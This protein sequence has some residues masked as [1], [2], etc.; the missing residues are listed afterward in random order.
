MKSTDK[1]HVKHIKRVMKAHTTTNQTIE[2]KAFIT[3]KAT[4]LVR[5]KI[6]TNR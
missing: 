1:A 5:F 3:L 4:V 6:T 2:G